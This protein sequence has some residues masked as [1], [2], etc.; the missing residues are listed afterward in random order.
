MLSDAIQYGKAQVA[1]GGS[2]SALLD[3]QLLLQYLLQCDRQWLYMHPEQ[4]L[5]EAQWQAYRDLIQLRRD[6]RPIAHLCGEREFWSLPFEVNA[7]TLIPRPDSEILVEQ[8]LALELPARARVLELGT[9]TGAIALALASERPEWQIEA[10]DRSAEAV[11]LA[12]RNRAKLALHGVGIYTSDWF[13]Q[14]GEERYDLII[15]NPPYIASDDDHL[16]Q[17]DVRFE[18]A[19]ALVADNQGLADLQII[20]KQSPAHLNLG[21]W[22][23]LEHGYQQGHQVREFFAEKGYKKVNTVPDYANLDRVTYAQCN[24]I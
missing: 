5:T 23:L 22:L 8:A 21:G 1:L 10:V 24:K 11:D 12:L 14:V 20:I 7:S 16:S 15:S 9:G 18:P 13:S 3:A 6:G 19:S 2:P 17:G 4:K